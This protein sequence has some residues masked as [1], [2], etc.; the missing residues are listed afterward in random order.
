LWHLK[1]KVR[2]KEAVY[3]KNARGWVK[4][5]IGVAREKQGRK[6]I[7]EQ[8]KNL[9]KFLFLVFNMLNKGI[10]MALFFPTIR[11]NIMFRFIKNLETYVF[12]HLQF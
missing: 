9:E 2:R 12:V 7:N 8:K 10:S 1:E 5:K 3:T 6:R 4:K 11:V